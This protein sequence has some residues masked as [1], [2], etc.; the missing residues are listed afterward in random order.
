[1][2]FPLSSTVPGWGSQRRPC[3]CGQTPL[4]LSRVSPDP[5]AGTV[6]CLASTRSTSLNSVSE[7]WKPTAP[8]KQAIQWL[9]GLTVLQQNCTSVS[10]RYCWNINRKYFTRTAATDCPAMRDCRAPQSIVM[11]HGPWWRWKLMYDCT[12]AKT[13]SIYVAAT[14]RGC[15]KSSYVQRMPRKVQ[16]N[17]GKR[18]IWGQVHWKNPR[19]DQAAYGP[20][21]Q[22]EVAWE[23]DCRGR[24]SLVPKL[25]D[26]NHMSSDPLGLSSGLRLLGCEGIP[27]GRD[28]GWSGLVGRLNCCFG[29][30]FFHRYTI[31]RNFGRQRLKKT[32]YFS[33]ICFVV[34]VV[35]FLCHFSFVCHCF[36]FIF[37]CH[38][39]FVCHFV[40]HLSCGLSFCL[41]FCRLQKLHF[42]RSIVIFS[43]IFRIIFDMLPYFW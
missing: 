10:L 20:V 28:C 17:A 16:R 26:S 21:R 30:I 38:F 22:A 35:I 27:Q 12:A 15:M 34:F 42:S 41:S 39:N 37:F 4:K 9:C 25:T 19:P 43:V 33:C 29:C 5:V 6:R 1:M 11:D 8:R 32:S 36:F 31:R 14:D 40:C 13:K 18:A 24:N 3:C 2:F 7:K 23:P